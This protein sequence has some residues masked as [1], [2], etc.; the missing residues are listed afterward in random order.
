MTGG[1]NDR[2]GDGKDDGHI[3]LDLIAEKSADQLLYSLRPD[4]QFLR[5]GDTWEENQTDRTELW[6][7]NANTF[8]RR[9]NFYK[10]GMYRRLALELKNLKFTGTDTFYLLVTHD[11]EV[12]T[13]SYYNMPYTKYFPT[14]S[15]SMIAR[16]GWDMGTDSNDVIAK[17]Q[18]SQVYVNNHQHHDA[19]NF[20]I[21][22]K[23]ILASESGYYVLYNT[24][25]DQHYTKS[26]IA[27]NTLSITSVQ[28]RYGVQNNPV[29]KGWGVPGYTD[30]VNTVVGHEYG[31]N[32][33]KP[34]YS[35]LAGDIARS[36]DANVQEAV[37]SML[38]L[39][40]E[41]DGNTEHPGR[42]NNIST[43]AQ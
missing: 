13:E 7:A 20:Q 10:N 40:L 17:M 6:D 5:E 14:P 33:Y 39:N 27:H 22:Y 21:Y 36:Y 12:D 35:Y 23:G 32:T 30:I 19:G 26:S 28:N 25:H 29:V 31:P 3:A 18:L 4:G 37:R 43:V 38:F 9:A 8:A 41:L 11:T 42:S 16:T 15:G 2:D 1:D 34:E 24:P